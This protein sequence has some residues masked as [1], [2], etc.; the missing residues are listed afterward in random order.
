[1]R[2]SLLTT[3]FLL[4]G[5][6]VFSQS[7]SYYKSISNPGTIKKMEVLDSCGLAVAYYDN[8]TDVCI[9]QYDCSGNMVWDKC[10][11]MSYPIIRDLIRVDDNGFVL[12]M[13]SSSS[14]MS[15]IKL[16]A[17]GTLQWRKDYPCA[18]NNSISALERS[19]SN[20]F[21]AAGLG[22]SNYNA[23]MKMD[24]ATGAIIWQYDYTG[25]VL[26]QGADICKTSDD[27]YAILSYSGGSNTG[28]YKVDENGN[29]KWAHAY[30]FGS[31]QYPWH[32]T[33]LSDTDILIT[34]QSRT[35]DPVKNEITLIR[36]DSLGVLQYVRSVHHSMCE[37]AGN[38]SVERSTGEIFVAGNVFVGG[39]ANVQGVVI[40]LNS[41]I[42]IVGEAHHNGN[43]T[44]SNAGYDDNMCIAVNGANDIYVG[45]TSDGAFIM[46]IGADESGLCDLD[47]LEYRILDIV[48]VDNTLTLT[49]EVGTNTV[50][51][52]AFSVFTQ[53]HAEQAL[54]GSITAVDELVNDV[55]E[56]WPNPVND[57]LSVKGPIGNAKVGIYSITGT[58]VKRLQMKSD[59]IDCADLL[60]GM[61][62]IK[63]S[64]STNAQF[65]FIKQ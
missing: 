45:G 16:N 33:E 27:N 20:T 18:Y 64:G 17:S 47:T 5:L 6:S 55:I 31:S 57:R 15:F 37:G 65:K 7:T 29:L 58:C 19:A 56:F 12:L 44:Y 51:S 23:L 39:A 36:T 30:N 25:G 9:K 34:G 60:P 1:M 24:A 46:K 26:L 4:F 28:L 59:Q 8:M 3:L 35:H 50:T 53:V 48:A 11:T 2:S 22:C 42:T 62:I 32:I 13:E 54:C 63:L 38:A 40:R 49:Q 21:L 52:N 43:V 14:N 10:F 61:Y 41:D